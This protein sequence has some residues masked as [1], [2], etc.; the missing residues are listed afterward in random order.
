M[1]AAQLWLIMDCAKLVAWF[2]FGHPFVSRKDD[3][4]AFADVKGA[5]ESNYSFFED[6]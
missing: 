3:D 5:Y 4:C 6:G 1:F 2:L